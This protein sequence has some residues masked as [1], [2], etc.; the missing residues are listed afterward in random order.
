MLGGLRV[1]FYGLSKNLTRRFFHDKGKNNRIVLV[2]RNGQEKIA[3]PKDL[4]NIKIKFTG[5]NNLLKIHLPCDLRCSCFAFRCNNSVIEIGG[6]SHV[7]FDI[8]CI[9][10]ESGV[11]VGEHCYCGGAEMVCCGNKIEIGNNC[12]FS[13]EILFLDD[14]HSILSYKNNRVLN[15]NKPVLKIGNHVWIGKKVTLLKNASVPDDCIVGYGSIVTKK[16]TEKHT[17]FAGS[18]ARI[19][20]TG[21][22]WHSLNPQSYTPQKAKGMP[23]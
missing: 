13:N 1:W 18:P 21:I 12:M 8:D 5:D 4:R 7:T 3:K 14:T 16:F 23:V 2:G 6:Y 9:A 11:F 10:D 15:K 22:T 17:I 20:K 19:V